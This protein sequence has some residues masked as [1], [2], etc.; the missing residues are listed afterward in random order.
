MQNKEKVDTTHSSLCKRHQKE[1]EALRENL[2]KRKKQQRAKKN[3]NL[4]S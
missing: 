4:N 2:K 1:A 3:Q